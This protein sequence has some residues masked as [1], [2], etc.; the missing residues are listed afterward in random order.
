MRVSLGAA[1]VESVRRLLT[2]R[3]IA[4]VG[5]TEN[6]FWSRTIIENLTKLGF[7]GEIYLVHPRQTEQFGRRCFPRMSAIPGPVD[8]AYVMTG[9]QHAMAVLNDCADKGV[10]GVTMLTAGFKGTDASGA[11]R[12]QELV[13]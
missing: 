10:P 5:A 4:L 9:T 6:S 11:Q 12:Q 8:H 7:G 3:S 13:D 1:R 2:P